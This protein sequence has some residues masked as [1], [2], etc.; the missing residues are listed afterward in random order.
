[1]SS[2]EGR[3]E[4]LWIVPVNDG[5]AVEIAALLGE[6]GETVAVT[7]QRWGASWAGLE[8]GVREAIERFRAAHPEGAIY[9]VELA[10]PD[11]YGAVNI[12]HHRYGEED[13]SH[14]R[15]SLEQVAEVLGVGLGRWRRL[16]AA[17]DRG[18][19]PAM[20]AEGATA[21][22]I[23]AVR[24]ADRAAQGVTAEQEAAAERDVA[25]TLPGTNSASGWWCGAR[26]GRARRM[27]TGCT[28]GPGRF[29][30]GGRVSG[31]TTGRGTGSWRIY[32]RGGRGRGAAGRRRAGI[33]GWRRRRRRSRRGFGSG[34]KRSSCLAVWPATRGEH[35]AARV[36]PGA[37]TRP[38]GRERKARRPARR[39]SRLLQ[40]R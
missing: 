39:G 2:E 21:E 16:V 35:S 1:M 4:R 33:S 17:N 32:S 13:R 15:S 8:A 18:Y 23:A 7:R 27:R 12:D 26:R 24:Q 38:R 36:R 9:G 3:P 10:G 14:P 20:E 28:A 31:I 11:P 37:R 5:E 19:I 25:G 22:E 30:C 6:H 34:G 29:C 40:I